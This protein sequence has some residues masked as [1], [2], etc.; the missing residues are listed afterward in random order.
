VLEDFSKSFGVTYLGG[1]MA[2]FMGFLILSY[3][4]I[5]SPSIPGVIMLLGV[6]AFI[7]GSALLLL[8]K[9]FM[10]MAGKIAKMK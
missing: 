3:Y 10:K 1:L 8:P 7:K 2:V 9:W 5:W 6:A 4:H